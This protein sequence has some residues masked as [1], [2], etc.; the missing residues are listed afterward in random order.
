M[1]LV[2]F[3]FAYRTPILSDSWAGLDRFFEPDREILVANSTDEAINAL[4]LSDEALVRIGRA[5][6]ERT[7]T[8]HT[9]TIRAL[10]L[11][12]M[13]ERSIA[14]ESGAQLEV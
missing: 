3:G 7:L 14:P 4:E 5:A 13:L 12:T 6:R 8:Q 1:K 10:E 11:E 9:S 2:I